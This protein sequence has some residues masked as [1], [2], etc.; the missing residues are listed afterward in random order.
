MGVVIFPY[1]Y[2]GNIEAP[3]KFYLR[4]T[5]LLRKLISF[6]NIVRYIPIISASPTKPSSLYIGDLTHAHTNNLE[7]RKGRE[8]VKIII[9]KCKILMETTWAKPL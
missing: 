9:S 2:R 8:T 6:S 4:K 5:Y 1:L 3:L 7:I